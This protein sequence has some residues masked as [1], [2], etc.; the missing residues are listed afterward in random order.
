M[1][2]VGP[3]YPFNIGILQG[4]SGTNVIAVWDLAKAEKVKLG[5]HS[6]DYA[7]FKSHDWSDSINL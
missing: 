3:F 2:F 6:I 1:K 5:Y 4:D 7:I